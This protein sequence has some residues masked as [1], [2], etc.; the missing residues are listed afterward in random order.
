MSLD[1]LLLFDRTRVAVTLSAQKAGFL[2]VE[3]SFAQNIREKRH[4]VV[5]VSYLASCI[6]TRYIFLLSLIIRN[7][8][9]CLPVHLDSSSLGLTSSHTTPLQKIFRYASLILQTRCY[10]FSR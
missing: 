8:W 4:V 6:V 2:L 9:M 3:L 10:G 7:T 5:V 1:S